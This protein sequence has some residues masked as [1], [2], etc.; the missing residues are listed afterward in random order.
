ME[1]DIE[2]YV[3]AMREVCL[4][5]DWGCVNE[6]REGACVGYVAE[7]DK[8]DLHRQAL[9]RTELGHTFLGRYLFD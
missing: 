3:C 4:V 8:F 1:G 5:E 7:D 6:R 2:E 9:Y